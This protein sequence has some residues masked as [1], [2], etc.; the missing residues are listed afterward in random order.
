M[1]WERLK[2]YSAPV[3]AGAWQGRLAPR[4]AFVF[5]DLHLLVVP[6][7]QNWFGIVVP[8][9]QAPSTVVN[10]FG[11]AL[12]LSCTRTSLFFTVSVSAW[13]TGVC[14]AFLADGAP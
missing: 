10:S 2:N 13:I 8:Y 4:Q 11:L 1:L 5:H 9:A 12:H 7:V 6:V 14:Q 3:I